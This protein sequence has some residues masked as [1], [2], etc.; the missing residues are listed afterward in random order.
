MKNQKINEIIHTNP[1][2]YDARFCLPHGETGG[3]E[4]DIK[5]VFKYIQQFNERLIRESKT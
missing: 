4:Y 5:K 3:V 2:C 1:N